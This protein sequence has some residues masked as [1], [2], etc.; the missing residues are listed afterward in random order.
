MKA[1]TTSALLLA[2]LFALPLTDAEA[3]G[4]WRA[5]EGNTR[6]WQLMTPEER[7]EHQARIR[8]FTSLAQCEAYREEHH[9][10]MEQ[11]AR[12][13]GVSLR[14]GGRDFCAHLRSDGANSTGKTQ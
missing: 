9:R 2:A 11:R 6:G 12:E 13:R 4:P 1:R 5:G 10:Q 7:V 8:S 3:R 14:G